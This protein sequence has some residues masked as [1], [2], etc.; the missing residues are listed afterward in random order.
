LVEALIGDPALRA[1]IDALLRI[2]RSARESEYGPPQPVIDAFITGELARLEAVP[3]PRPQ[4]FDGTG[5]DRLLLETVLNRGLSA[6]ADST[7]ETNGALSGQ[8]TSRGC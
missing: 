4:P 8:D 1:A 5:L 2:K 7:G 3:P 6:M